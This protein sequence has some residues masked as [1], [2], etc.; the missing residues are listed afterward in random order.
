M[1]PQAPKQAGATG[2]GN[3]QGN[4]KFLELIKQL[5]SQKKGQASD[6]A[7]TNGNKAQSEELKKKFE[8]LIREAKERKELE[9]QKKQQ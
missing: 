9:Q 4:Q 6:P 2:P 8:K 5:Q 7:A 1:D 3:D